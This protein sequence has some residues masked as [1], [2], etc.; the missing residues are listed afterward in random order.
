MST[1][2]DYML[3]SIPA[4]PA[5]PGLARTL[6]QDQLNEWDCLHISDDAALIASELATNAVEAAPNTHIR[7]QLSRRPLEILIAV[8]DTSDRLPQMRPAPDLT[9][10]ASA[11][12]GSPA[13]GLGG[14]GLPIVSTLAVNC[15]FI[16]EP[17]GGKWV[18][19]TLKP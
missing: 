4:S 18:W 19:A 11:L 17:I 12:S 9:P 7:F 8:W 13:N 16:P 6:T 1:K 3:I 5:A 10:D 14:W 2:T 15:G